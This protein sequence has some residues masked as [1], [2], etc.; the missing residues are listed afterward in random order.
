MPNAIRKS[1]APHLYVIYNERHT[2][3]PHLLAG[4]RVVLFDGE[5]VLCR[6]LVKGLNR[7]DPAKKIHL[8][9]VQ[10]PT[11]QDLL[12]W[13][14]LPTDNVTTITYIANGEVTVRADAFIA[15]LG[16]LSWPWR[17]LR[18]VLRGCPRALRDRAYHTVAGHRYQWFGKLPA[19]TPPPAEGQGRR[20]L[21]GGNHP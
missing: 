5:C 15:L 12:R 11:G 14:G 19:G 17:A 2:P 10:S 21:D 6:H 13:A 16:Q 7:A 4:E 20:Y 3:P 1:T 8:A 18:M 9:T